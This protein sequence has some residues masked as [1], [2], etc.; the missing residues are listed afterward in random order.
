MFMLRGIWDEP[1]IMGTLEP[2]SSGAGYNRTQ[3]FWAQ[4]RWKM[5]V[6][7]REI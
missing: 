5:G 7:K 6:R 1:E 4:M 3:F 2:L